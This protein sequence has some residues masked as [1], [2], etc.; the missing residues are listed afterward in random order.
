MAVSNLGLDAIDNDFS[1][2]V[3][4]APF[5]P[6]DFAHY[7][8]PTA[9]HVVNPRPIYDDVSGDDKPRGRC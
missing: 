4:L 9:G 6:Q 8:K 1:F 5:E 2:N 3:L 7:G